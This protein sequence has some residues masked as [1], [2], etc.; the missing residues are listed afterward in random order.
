MSAYEKGMLEFRAEKAD[1]LDRSLRHR[2][3]AGA[4]WLSRQAWDW[5]LEHGHVTVNGRKALKAGANVNA[6]DEIRVAFPGPLGLTPSNPAALVW[7]APDRSLALFDKPVGID[8][9][10]LLPWDGSSFASQAAAFAVGE[11][12]ISAEAFAALAPAPQLEGGLLQRLDRDT[13]GLI[14]VAFTKAAKTRARDLFAAGKIEKDYLAL[15]AAP[16]RAGVYRAWLADSSGAR[17]RAFAEKPRSEAEEVSLQVE[18]LKDSARGALLRVRTRFGRRHVV[19]ASLAAFGAPLVGDRTYGGPETEPFHQL[20]A[21]AIVGLSPG[22]V[23]VDPPQ[24]F[25][26][27][28]ERLGLR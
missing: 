16:F 21:S 5:L 1:R 12:G 17:V 11:G 7:A 4:E 6:G 3:F 15:V 18:V 20:H 8:S 28:A 13:S 9:V 2:D 24:S 14:A 23:E 19:R 25:L 22:R 27:S 26:D 10:P